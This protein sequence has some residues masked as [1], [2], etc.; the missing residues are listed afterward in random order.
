MVYGVLSC[1][2]CMVGGKRNQSSRRRNLV[3]V[4]DA[5]RLHQLVGSPAPPLLT[6]L[7][8]VIHSSR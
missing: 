4:G 1:N 6:P 8:S 2:D 7:A 3:S 5:E